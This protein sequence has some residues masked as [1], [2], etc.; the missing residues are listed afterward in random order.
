MMGLWTNMPLS[1]KFPTFTLQ[2][3]EV[4]EVAYLKQNSLNCSLNSFESTHSY[5]CP[6]S[7]QTDILLG[8]EI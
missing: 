7:H 4:G 6:A 5:F 1:P 3:R 8:T 2:M